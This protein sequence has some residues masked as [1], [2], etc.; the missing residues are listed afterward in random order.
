MLPEEFAPTRWDAAKI[1]TAI[2]IAVFFSVIIVRWC[3]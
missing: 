2:A 1:A 3:A